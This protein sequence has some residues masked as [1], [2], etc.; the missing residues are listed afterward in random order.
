MITPQIP[1]YAQQRELNAFLDMHAPIE[2]HEVFSDKPQIR[3][4]L[5]EA[6]NL[7][8]AQVTS[9]WL[10]SDAKAFRDLV[11]NAHTSIKIPLTQRLKD[12]F[13]RV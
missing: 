4:L 8:R 2:G 11:Q 1:S 12:L 9:D 3:T 13:K 7:G 6:Y 5:Y 10:H